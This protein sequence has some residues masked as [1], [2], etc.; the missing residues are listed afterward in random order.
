MT[1]NEIRYK[2]KDI[3]TNRHGIPAK[4]AVIRTDGEIVLYKITPTSRKIVVKITVTKSTIF[5]NR[6]FLKF[7]TREDVKVKPTI[8]FTVDYDDNLMLIKER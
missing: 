1:L 3:I 4:D 6:Y 8:V 2:I 7:Y 5:E